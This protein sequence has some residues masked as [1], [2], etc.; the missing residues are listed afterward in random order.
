MHWV[1]N[2]NAEPSNSTSNSPSASTFNIAQ[3]IQNRCMSKLKKKFRQIKPILNN[4]KKP[5][6]R[7]LF[8]ICKSRSFKARICATCNNPS[9][10]FRLSLKIHSD[11]MRTYGWKM[12][13]LDFSTTNQ[14]HLLG[15]CIFIIRFQG[16]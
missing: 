3:V 15:N 12:G 6:Y 16:A 2:I 14:T 7:I 1:D 9:S 5:V 11:S 4:H 10:Y 13:F 8:R